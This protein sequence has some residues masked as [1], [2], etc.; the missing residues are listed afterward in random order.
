MSV[1]QAKRSVA[2]ILAAAPSIPVGVISANELNARLDALKSS[3]AVC[4]EYAV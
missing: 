1:A 3:G 4:P 2:E